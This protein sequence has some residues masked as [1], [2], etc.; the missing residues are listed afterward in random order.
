MNTQELVSAMSDVI[1]RADTIQHNLAWMSNSLK[2]L[3]KTDDSRWAPFVR[4]HRRHPK[5]G[6][7]AH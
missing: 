4:K 2:A 3:R 7:F 6:R 1:S 5:N